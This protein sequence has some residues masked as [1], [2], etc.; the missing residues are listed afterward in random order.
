MSSLCIFSQVWGGG[1]TKAS[2]KTQVRF[3]IG[4]M[5]WVGGT[6]GSVSG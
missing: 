6:T 1:F 3:F 4:R 2:K 5:P